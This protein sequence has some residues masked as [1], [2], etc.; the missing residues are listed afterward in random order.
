M[1]K[2]RLDLLGKRLKRDVSLKQKYT[3]GVQDYLSKGYEQRVTNIGREDGCVWYLPHH[4]VIHPRKPGKVRLV[5]DCSARYQ[6]TSLNDSIHQGPDLTNKLLGVLLKF[7]QEPIALS[8]DIEEMFC[9]VRVPPHAKDVLRFLW[10]EDDDPEKPLMHY[11]MTN[12]L[13]GGVY[14]PSAATFALRQVAEGNHEVF[15]KDAMETISKNF[16]VDDCLKSVP[17]EDSAITLT[18]ELQELL[19]EGGFRLTKM[20]QQL[21]ECDEGNTNQWLGEVFT[22][23]RPRSWWPALR[24][25]PGCPLGCRKGL[26]HVRCQG[27]WQTNNK[28]RCAERY[29]LSIWST[30]LC[31][32]LCGESQDSVPRVMPLESWL[33]WRN[34]GYRIRTVAQMAGW[35]TSTIWDDRAKKLEIIWHQLFTSDPASPFLWCIRDGIWCGFLHQKGQEVL[36]GDVKG[37]ACTHQANEHTTFGAARSCRGYRSGPPHKA[38]P[39]NSHWWDILLEWQ[40]HSTS[41]HQ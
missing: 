20:A 36:S 18:A 8:A 23:T 30:R 11:R 32:P 14:S 1:A 12:H 24:K 28:K 35:L 6:G 17:T 39:G 38:P 37:Q 22:W 25:N 3:E 34:T 7:R 31:E 4:P 29:Q 21:Q 13:F 27:H 2:R 15:N 40:H 41:V 26:F 9:Q 10:W 16:Y 19:A 33:G 5:F